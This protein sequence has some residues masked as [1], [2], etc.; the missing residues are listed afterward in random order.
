MNCPVCDR[1][2]NSAVCPRCGYNLENDLLTHNMLVGLSSNEMKNYNKSIEKQKALYNE[3]VALRKQRTQENKQLAEG[4]FER[5]YYYFNRRRYTTAESYFLQAI[6]YN[7]IQ[8]YYYLGIMYRYGISQGYFGIKRN[9]EKAFEYL[10]QAAKRMNHAVRAVADMYLRGEGVQANEEEGVK[11]F[12]RLIRRGDV[13]AFET[14]L[15]YYNKGYGCIVKD[16][17]K[18]EALRRKYGE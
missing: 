16:K 12:E 6:E 10:L 14:L 9:P 2:V 8:S 7:H 1:K 5:G 13:Q 15:E 3:L 4:L 17:D 11:M 18:A